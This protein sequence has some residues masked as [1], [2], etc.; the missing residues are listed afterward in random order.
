ML[1]GEKD[2]EEIS[3]SYIARKAVDRYEEDMGP[4]QYERK[5]S[6]LYAVLNTQQKQ[7]LPDAVNRILEEEN[8]ETGQVFEQAYRA[9]ERRRI[10]DQPSEGAG[11]VRMGP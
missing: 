11:K 6:N 1:F 8:S 4:E 3:L 9:L 7:E 10:Q 2:S 5:I